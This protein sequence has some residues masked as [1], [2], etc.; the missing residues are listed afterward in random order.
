VSL[1]LLTAWQR[2]Q[3]GRLRSNSSILA[4]TGPDTSDGWGAIPVLV[5]ICAAGGFS[6]SVDWTAEFPVIVAPVVIAV[7]CLVGPAT[8]PGSRPHR[9]VPRSRRNDLLA[10]L[11]IVVAGLSI[12]AAATGFGVATKIN[13]SREA[14]SDGNLVEATHEARE[15]IDTLPLSSEPRIQLALIQELQ[16]EYA[17]ALITLTEAIERAPDSS[18]SYLL[19][20]RLLLKLG[21]NRASERAF[22]KAR[23]LD[24]TGPI[25][26]E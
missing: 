10:S 8:E 9:S 7:A 6:M 13:A 24:P 14:V 22:E 18:S 1:A 19:K 15:A 17:I 3:V 5:A 12:W 26:G 20:A 21:R 16:G 4:P 23:S 2:W 25:F 11:M